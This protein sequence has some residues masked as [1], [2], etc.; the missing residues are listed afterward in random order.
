LSPTDTHSVPSGWARIPV[1]ACV[2]KSGPAGSWSTARSSV[3]E[4]GVVPATVHALSRIT[5]LPST[6][7]V[8]IV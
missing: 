8:R 1:I 6:L 3:N 2:P 5:H 7:I 4:V